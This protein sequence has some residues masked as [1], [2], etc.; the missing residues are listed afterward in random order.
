MQC[1]VSHQNHLGMCILYHDTQF[2][3]SQVLSFTCSTFFFVLTYL[4][5]LGLYKQYPAHRYTQGLNSYVVE[6]GLLHIRP[7]KP[8]QK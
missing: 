3:S 1:S 4:F 5:F 2:L 8:S 7:L 6:N